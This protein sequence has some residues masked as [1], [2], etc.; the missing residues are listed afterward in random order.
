MTTGVDEPGSAPDTD[1]QTMLR[2]ATELVAHR[3]ASVGDA[4]VTVGP[5]MVL[6]ELDAT[7]DGSD[8]RDSGSDSRDDGS[9]S[10][11]DALAGVAHR[12]A[13]DEPASWPAEPG[14]L[15]DLATATDADRL[16]RAVG[17]AALNALSVPDLSWRTGDPMAAL[18]GTVAVVATVGLFRP[19]FRKFGGCEVRVVERDP[20]V[21]L[22]TPADVTASVYAPDEAAAAFAGVDVCFVTGSTLVY[23][24]V[25]RYAAAAGAADVPLVVLVGA[26]ASFRPEPAFDAGFDVLAGARVA[27]PDA[28]RAHVLAGDCGTD[29]HDNGLE[30]VYAAATDDLPGS[31]LSTE[32][33]TERRHRQTAPETAPESTGEDSED[34]P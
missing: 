17:I 26:T 11:D 4:R 30:K 8:S 13:G 16:S 15:L 34:T 28:V 21:A 24:G 32:R 22:D 9:D 33:P 20:D 1:G 3:T 27:E 6:V 19:A 23:G 5:R 12:P 7:D 29:L 10:C 18:D 2:R 25:D 14:A 31:T